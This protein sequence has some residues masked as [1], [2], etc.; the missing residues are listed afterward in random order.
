MIVLLLVFQLVHAAPI[1]KSPD[2][3]IK[4]V[5]QILT[6]NKQLENIK[7]YGPDG[8]LQLLS[9]ANSPQESIEVRWNAMMAMAR[10]GGVHSIPDLEK[11][12][13]HSLWYMRSGALNAL[14]MVEKDRGLARAKLLLK[15]DPALLVRASALQVVAQQSTVD[16]KYLWTELYNPLNFDNGYSLSIRKSIIKVLSKTP[17]KKEAPKFIALIR[18]KDPEVRTIAIHALESLSK[19]KSPVSPIQDSVVSYWQGWYEKAN[20]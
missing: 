12:L 11:N 15:N 14:S 17:S 1:K 18:D 5:R 4:D 13:T 2:E 7:Q 3:M 8:Y 10:I 16:S 20:F 9:I 6:E 19:K